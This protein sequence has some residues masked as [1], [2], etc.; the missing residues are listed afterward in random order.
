MGDA[1]TSQ[2]TPTIAS[3]PAEG[4]QKSILSHSPWK[5]PT[6]PTPWFSSL[7]DYEYIFCYLSYLVCGI[8]LQQTYQTNAML[9]KC[10]RAPVIHLEMTWLKFKWSENKM[11]S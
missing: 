9:T 2:E 5:E 1:S 7:H 8:L 3:K 6:R 10:A 4:Q 11:I